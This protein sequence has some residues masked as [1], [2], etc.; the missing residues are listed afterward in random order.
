MEE[1]DLTP[2]EPGEGL[3]SPTN[4]PLWARAAL[5]RDPT[6]FDFPQAVRLLERLDPEGR[7]PGRFVDPATEVVRFSVHPSLAFPPSAIHSLDRPGDGE[8]P[9]TL[10][11]NFFG[12]VG[13]MGV[14]PHEYTRL[15]AERERA[16]D[17]APRAFLDLFNHRAISLLY[18]A[19]RVHRSDLAREAGEADRLQTHA[20]DLAGVWSP[21][22]EPGQAPRGEAGSLLRDLVAAFAGLLG[23]QRRSAAALE[24]LVEGAF[25]VETAVEEFVGGWFPIA[26]RDRC[27]LGEE[28]EEGRLGLGAVAGEETWDPQARVRI[29][30]G[31]MGWDDYA[32]FLPSGRRHAILKDLTRFFADDQFEFEVQLVLRKEDVPGCAP[33]GEGVDHRLGWSTWLRTRPPDRNVDDTVFL[34]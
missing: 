25:G 14:L 17:G 12:L 5:E 18:R 23:P 8:G 28:E 27:A 24:Q 30:L 9:A 32:S 7:S 34:L 26:E 4:G 21:E 6:A 3:P 15:V 11:V 19:S 2:S 1:P 29:R 33:G 22:A 20:L 31:P 13:P 16:R 10:V